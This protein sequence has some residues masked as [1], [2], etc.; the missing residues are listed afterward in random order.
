MPYVNP[1]CS[2]LSS[3]SSDAFALAVHPLPSNAVLQPPLPDEERYEGRYNGTLSYAIR[4]QIKTLKPNRIIEYVTS[5]AEGRRVT[6]KQIRK[7]LDLACLIDTIRRRLNERSYFKRVARLIRRTNKAFNPDCLR[8][9]YKRIKTQL[10][11]SFINAKS[12]KDY[13]ILELHRFWRKCSNAEAALRLQEQFNTGRFDGFVNKSTFSIDGRFR[14]LTP[15]VEDAIVDDAVNGDVDI[16]AIVD[17]T[18]LLLILDG[19][20]VYKAA[21]F[22]SKLDRLRIPYGLDI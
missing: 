10:V 5:R 20:S 19:A 22:R 14:S 7:R 2:F 18:M 16:P 9:K 15:I 6:Y 11:Y 13:I 21:T 12:L 3:S 4:T 17:D 1:N 8:P